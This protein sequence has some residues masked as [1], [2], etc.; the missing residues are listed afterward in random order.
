MLRDLTNC[1]RFAF[2][3]SAILAAAFAAGCVSPEKNPIQQPGTN[4]NSSPQPTPSASPS[5]AKETQAANVPFTLPILDALLSDESTADEAKNDVQMSDQEVQKLREIS[6]NYVLTLN[7]TA[8]DEKRSTKAA[9]A[10]ARKQVQ[11]VLGS[12]RTERL[13]AFVQKNWEGGEQPDTKPNQVPSD[14]RVVVNTPAYRMDIFQE[15]KLIK[16]YKIGIGYPEFPIPTGLKKASSIIF[17]PTWTPPDEPWVKGKVEPGKKVEAGSKLN[18]L[19][20]IKIPIG[21]PT[22]VHGGKSPSRLGTFASHGCVG[23]TN[24]QVQDFAMQIAALSGE[25]LNLA[26]IKAYEKAKTETKEDKLPQ[27][28]PVELRYETIV[29]EDGVLKIYRDVYEKGTNTEENLG[30]VLSNYGVSLDSLEPNT[31]ASILAALEQMA[32]N[33]VGQPAN[34]AKAGDAKKKSK[35]DSSRVTRNIKGN[36][37][38]DFALP[39]LAGKGYPAPVG[40]KF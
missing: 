39:E 17:N 16:T 30:R 37:E 21:G 13:I 19:G 32:T 2:L 24:P 40:A 20:P 10:D 4:A 1:F 26:D 11:Q 38:L 33:A 6:R 27:P 14:T 12:E 18:P 15:G 8:S 9:S 22:L 36:K 34:E 3:F 5:P 7:D 23:L 31:R 28:V 29:V 25:N 35:P